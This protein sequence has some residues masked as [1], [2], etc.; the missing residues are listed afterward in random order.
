MFSTEYDRCRELDHP[1]I[2]NFSVSV[3]IVLGILVSYLP[4]HYKIIARRSSRGLSPMFVLLGTVSGTA[5]IANIL[6]LPESTRDMGCCSKIGTFPCAAA[7]LGIAQIGVQWT[8]F[9]FIMLLFLIFFPRN[10]QD[11]EEQ[12]SSLPTWKEAILVLALS[13]TFFVFAFLGSVVFVYAAP[14]HIRGWA[15]FLGLLG[16]TL[17]AVQYIPQI[18]TTWRLQEPGSLSVPMMCIQTPGSFV[19]AASLAVRLGP[20]G[21]SAWGLFILTGCLQ[22]CL[23]VMSL[24]FLWRDRKAAKSGSGQ[25][26]NG[27]GVSLR[28]EDSEQTP[29]LAN[30]RDGNS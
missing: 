16:T 2:F 10:G 9:F 3:F 19:F 17:A 18:M 13:L 1:D 5:S 25:D 15:N 24:W 28:T 4:Q 14:N 6:T 22:G 30:E 26:V 23:L 27:N 12:D 20:G 29:L 7:L 11:P 21:W 8:C